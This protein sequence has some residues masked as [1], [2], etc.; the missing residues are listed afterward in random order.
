M[1]CNHALACAFD[2]SRAIA[3]SASLIG[4]L[5][6]CRI[7]VCTAAKSTS[8]GVDSGCGDSLAS[9]IGT[10]APC[11]AGGGS[12]STGAGGCALEISLTGADSLLSFWGTR[13]ASRGMDTVGLASAEDSSSFENSAKSTCG[14][15]AG[16]G[17]ATLNTSSKEFTFCGFGQGSAPFFCKPSNPAE[18]SP[19]DRMK[20]GTYLSLSSCSTAPAQ[21]PPLLRSELTTSEV[22]ANA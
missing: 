11:V 7:A 10:A 19:V 4:V 14:E 8:A 20:T 22:S 2:T 6:S 9:F 17:I 21:V 13:A 18:G 15:V 3:T 16:A 5:N 12:S 1:R